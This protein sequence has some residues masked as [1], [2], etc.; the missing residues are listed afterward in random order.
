MT[1]QEFPQAVRGRLRVLVDEEMAAR[2]G[3]HGHVSANVPPF[4][5]KVE[6]FRHDPLRAIED[7]RGAIDG[8]AFARVQIEVGMRCGAIVGAGGGDH[9][10][11][12]PGATVVGELLGIEILLARRAPAKQAG[13]V[14]E[15][16]IG[17]DQPF[18]KGRRLLQEIPVP[19]SAR[20]AA[21]D[22]GESGVR[23]GYVHQGDCAHGARV[24]ERQPMG[25]PRAAIVANK[26][27][28][29]KPEAAHQAGLVARHGAKGVVGAV[30]LG[31]RLG[32]VPRNR[33]SRRRPG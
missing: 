27:E 16:G 12:S 8:F 28:T 25:C 21:V 17:A 2:H 11:I 30:G 6:G 18:R 13:L 14:E 20:E 15:I 31:G 23:R 26:M 1:Q 4:V 29:F 7:Q 3:Q 32:G 9:R 19:I 10:R 5:G 33:A 22:L 24:V